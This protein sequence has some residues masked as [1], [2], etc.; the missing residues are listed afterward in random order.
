MPGERRLWT[1]PHGSALRERVLEDAR[2]D[3]MS[4]WVVPSAPARDQVVRALGLKHRVARGPQV[5]CWD[6][7]WWAIRDERADG[8][9]RL[10]AAA[11]RAA[12]RQAIARARRDGDLK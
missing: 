1:G 4:L 12:L 10:S 5:W 3:P 9:A 6:E 8:P 7:L 11:A 2:A